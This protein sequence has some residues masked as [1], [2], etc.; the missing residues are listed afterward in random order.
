MSEHEK[1]M[2]L[3]L[4]EAERALEKCDFP[5]GCVIV[6]K[7]G[8]VATGRREHSCDKANELDHAEIVALRS[9]VE[10]GYAADSDDLVAYATM[11]PCLMCFSSLI[12]NNIKTI[13]YAYEDVMGGGTNLPLD[14][15]S[16]LYASMEVTVIPH[17]LRAESLQLFQRF[18]K[19]PNNPYWNDSLLCRYTLAQ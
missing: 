7:S 14:N 1:Y 12:L 6:G 15:L 17:V 3:A 2:R 9:V 5:V 11:E 13:V 8:V 10:G 4:A 19:N 16:P 18:F